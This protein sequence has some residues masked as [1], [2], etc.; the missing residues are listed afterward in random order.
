[1]RALLGQVR[2]PESV[3]HLFPP[4][5]KIVA[6]RVSVTSRAMPWRVCLRTPARFREECTCAYTRAFQS[7]LPDA[8]HLRRSRRSAPTMGFPFQYA[9]GAL[10]VQFTMAFSSLISLRSAS[11]GFMLSSG[12]P[13][14]KKNGALCDLGLRERSWR[15]TAMCVYIYQ[16]QNDQSGKAMSSV[17]SLPQYRN[18]GGGG[19]W[20]SWSRLPAPTT[21]RSSQSNMRSRSG[22]RPG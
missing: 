20:A 21:G 19:G 5:L 11:H 16:P 3:P 18:S 14:S 1:M 9:Y 12:L 10:S 22:T 17:V 2:S 4:V 13:N 15:R 7:R 8:L 6:S